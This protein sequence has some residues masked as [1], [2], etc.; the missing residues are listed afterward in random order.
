MKKTAP[1]FIILALL[2]TQA[3]AQFQIPYGFSE[4]KGARIYIDFDGDG[5]K[6]IVTIIRQIEADEFNERYHAFL[7]YLT[8]KNKPHILKFG[9]I[10]HFTPMRV[11]NNTIRFGYVLRGTG[12]IA[13]E[14]TIRYNHTAGKIQLIGFDFGHRIRGWHYSGYREVSYNLL[15]GDFHVTNSLT[16]FKNVEY[17]EGRIDFFRGNRRINPVFWDDIDYELIELLSSVGEEF[18]YRYEVE[19]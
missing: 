3:H 13:N 10:G 4:M 5:E 19:M 2:C 17:P 9:G 1:I 11:R 16:M 6:D 7:I 8:S 18:E 15:T 14:F 12:V